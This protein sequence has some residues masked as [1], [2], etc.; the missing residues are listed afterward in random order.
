MM[1]GR[2]KVVNE[3]KEAGERKNA[4]FL[5]RIVRVRVGKK[6]KKEE[7]EEEEEEEEKKKKKKK[8]A[9]KKGKTQAR[10]KSREKRWEEEGDGG[11]VYNTILYLLPR[12]SFA[13]PTCLPAIF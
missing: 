6:K 4:R 9:E 3:G 2:V 12:L 5:M 8:K 11:G 10:K 13:S 7:E 1:Y